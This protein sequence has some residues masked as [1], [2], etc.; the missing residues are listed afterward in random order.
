MKRF[1]RFEE[2]KEEKEVE[3]GKEPACFSFWNVPPLSGIFHVKRIKVL[4]PPSNEIWTV[5][6]LE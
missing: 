3:E 4:L 5:L 1:E 2:G 6:S